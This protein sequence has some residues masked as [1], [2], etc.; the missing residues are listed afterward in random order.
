MPVVS[1]K[2]HPDAYT[3]TNV[4]TRATRAASAL[5]AYGIFRRLS[6]N[7][8]WLGVAGVVGVAYTFDPVK[9]L[10]LR[11]WKY[12]HPNRDPTVLSGLYDFVRPNTF[13][14]LGVEPTG[15]DLLSDPPPT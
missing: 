2:R 14:P 3:P 13:S 10:L 15:H 5:L 8:G 4:S 7:T 9:R 12:T 6:P 1:P 11:A